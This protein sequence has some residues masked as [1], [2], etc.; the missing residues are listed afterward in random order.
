MWTSS[1]YKRPD[2]W[3][4]DD[5]SL[6]GLAQQ[7]YEAFNDRIVGDNDDEK[8][9]E[10]I[11]KL[12][13]FIWLGSKLPAQYQ[14][15]IESWKLHHPSWEIMLWDDVKVSSFNLVNADIFRRAPNYGMKSDILRYEILH[16]YGGVYVDID[17]ACFRN[18]D[19]IV[20]GCVFFAG[21]SHTSVLELNNGILGCVPHQP[22]MQLLIR[23]ISSQTAMKTLIQDDGLA[24]SIGTFLGEGLLDILPSLKSSLTA[25]NETIAHTGPGLL[26]RIVSQYLLVGDSAERQQVVLFPVDVFHPVPN[27]VQLSLATTDGEDYANDLVTRYSTN[28]TRAIHWW[29]CSWQ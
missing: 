20:N 4:Q 29:Q 13:H 8:E 5:E 24:A 11:P 7:Q 1:L 25:P 9:S 17:Y 16:C 3:C 10:S 2:F 18:I 6:I 26:T 14:R 19:D 12:L 27:N 21:F 15:M 22:I 23:D 28:R